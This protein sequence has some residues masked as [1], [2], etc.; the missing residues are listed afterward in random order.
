MSIE[1]SPG[2]SHPV[3]RLHAGD[4]A[5]TADAALPF[6]VRPSSDGRENAAYDPEHFRE[7]ESIAGFE[8]A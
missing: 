7:I 2:S 6:G 8:A 5:A 4:I 1:A 3:E